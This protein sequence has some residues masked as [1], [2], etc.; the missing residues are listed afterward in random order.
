MP[1]EE[2][3]T[4]AAD[5]RS[6]KEREVHRLKEAIKRYLAQPPPLDQKPDAWLMAI[7]KA[8]SDRMLSDN[9]QAF[10]LSLT[11]LPEGLV[12]TGLIPDPRSAGGALRLRSG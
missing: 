8:R 5:E 9:C 10:C 11:T 6:A 7:Y 4:K 3:P 12:T 2:T 1:K